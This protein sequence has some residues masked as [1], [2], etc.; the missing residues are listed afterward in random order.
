MFALFW[1]HLGTVG[2]IITPAQKLRLSSS[3][4]ATVIE[5][6]LQ[7]HYYYIKYLSSSIIHFLISIVES[8]TSKPYNLKNERHESPAK[9]SPLIYEDTVKYY[10]GHFLWGADYNQLAG[11]IFPTQRGRFAALMTLPC[12]CASQ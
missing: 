11:A 5:S 7:R 12:A 6:Q 8:P 2:T 9:T 3:R 10:K 4:L 1:V